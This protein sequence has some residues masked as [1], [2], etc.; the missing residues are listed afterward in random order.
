MGI[1]F[2]QVRAEEKEL[3]KKKRAKSNP[4]DGFEN[5]TN[6]F[7]IALSGGGVRSAT[8]NLGVLEIFNQ[9]GILKLADYLST[10]SG[11]GYIGGYVHTGLRQYQ[12]THAAYDRLFL[13]DDIKY[14]RENASYLTPGKG[15]HKACTR[16]RLGGVFFFSLLMNFVWIISLFLSLFFAVKVM[17]ESIPVSDL[18]HTMWYVAAFAAATLICHFF[19]HTLAWTRLWPSKALYAAE[20][21]IFSILVVMGIIQI[22]LGNN[23]HL[24]EPHVESVFKLSLGLIRF[25]FVPHNHEWLFESTGLFAISFVAFFI[26]GFF[27]NPNIITMHSFYKDS[28]AGSFFRPDKSRTDKM[29]LKDLI[30]DNGN[31]D[32]GIAPYPL[33]NGCL[34]LRGEKPEKYKG[35]KA[36][37]YF[38]FSPLYCGSKLTTYIK[39]SSAHY[40]D[41]SVAAAVAIS[42]AALNPNM[43]TRTNRVLAFLMTLLNMRL[44]FWAPNPD[45][46]ILPFLLNR[47]AWWPYYHVLEL[48]GQ[49]G[50]RNRRISVTDGGH[51]ENLGVYELLQRKCKLIIAIDASADPDYSFSD[52]RNLVIRARQ[53]LGLKIVFRQDPEIYIRPKASAG[54]SDSHFVIA[55]ISELPGKKEPN[56]EEYTGLLVYVKSSLRPQKKFYKMAGNKETGD[57]FHYKSFHPAFPHESTVDQFFDEDQWEAYYN[58]GKYM[59]ADLLK[60]DLRK[61]QAAPRQSIRSID[62]LITMFS[63]IKDKDGKDLE[64]HYIC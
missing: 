56:E 1:K 44:G 46:K 39:T 48:L 62:D 14:L 13:P 53:E 32:C 51:I 59:A 6:I 15:Y 24:Q 49:A 25:N 50:A 35:S 26:T 38:L 43:G 60:F 47:I 23:W 18:V 20:G 9:C 64:A 16:F 42:G 63:N 55:D 34:N 57:S 2:E 21:L 41:M 30:V 22:T 61:E 37:D 40:S 58:L 52:L 19:L 45:S 31:S 12:A 3:F 33:I 5:P 10:V 7:G 4:E 11:G 54:F 8:I 28:I 36:S 29:K 17:A 27:A